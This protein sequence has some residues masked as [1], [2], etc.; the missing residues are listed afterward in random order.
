MTTARDV[1]AGALRLIGALAAGETPDAP[2]AADGLDALNRMMHGWKARGVDLAHTDLALSDTV[3]LADEYREGLE[4]LLA[5]RLAPEYERP[6]SP[7][8]LRLGEEAW[9]AIQLAFTAPVDLTVETGLL[10]MPGARR[11]TSRL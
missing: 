7:D 3:S 4:H 2:E 8:L 6:A 11:G 10:R 1:V 9:R 5:V